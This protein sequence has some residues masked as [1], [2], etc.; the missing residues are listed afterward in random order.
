MVD[1][2]VLEEDPALDPVEEKVGEP[3]INS[4]EKEEEDPVEDED[5]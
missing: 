3:E 1:F 2:A 4:V 5:I